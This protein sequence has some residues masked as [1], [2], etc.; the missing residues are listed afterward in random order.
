MSKEL[1]SLRHR[2]VPRFFY[3][4][5]V[6]VKSG[7]EGIGITAAQGC[8]ASSLQDPLMLENLWG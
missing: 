7:A 2:D 5:E 3:E 4:G 8:A 6:A 1:T